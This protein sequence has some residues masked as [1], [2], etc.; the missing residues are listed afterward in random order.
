MRLTVI[1]DDWSQ[2][3]VWRGSTPLAYSPNLIAGNVLKYHYKKWQAM[4][5]TKFVSKQYMT[6]SGFSQYLNTDETTYT[7][8]V[9]SLFCTTDFDLNYNFTIHKSI[10]ATVGCTVYNLSA[11]D[12]KA[13]A[14]AP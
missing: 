10:T 3:D 6:N 11:S 14:P 8:A 4:L 1:N 2:Q 5:Q 12:M 7:S 13:M 9:I